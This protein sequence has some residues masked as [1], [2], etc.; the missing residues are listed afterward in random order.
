MNDEVKE[1]NIPDNILIALVDLTNGALN[2]Y[3]TPKTIELKHKLLLDYITNLQY[4]YENQIHRYK[5]LKDY[6]TNL[7]NKNEEL[8]KFR[9]TIRKDET[10]IP[11]VITRTYKRE[12]DELKEQK[13]KALKKIQRIIDYGY[14][15]DG[16]NDVENLKKLIDALVDYAIEAKDILGG[17]K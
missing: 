12:Y 2:Y 10:K 15:Y 6:A 3:K 14:D 17:D 9:Y 7:Q 4:K 5:N 11:P 8:R 13:K 1:I 16:F